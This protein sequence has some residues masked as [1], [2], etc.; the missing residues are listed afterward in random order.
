MP[1]S[2]TQLPKTAEFHI[3]SCPVTIRDHRVITRGGLTG[4]IMDIVNKTDTDRNQL[5][6]FEKYGISYEAAIECCAQELEYDTMTLAKAI[7]NYLDREG[8]PYFDEH[9][10]PEAG[11]RF[12]ECVTGRKIAEQFIEMIR[13]CDNWEDLY[14]EMQLTS[15]FHKDMKGRI[16]AEVKQQCHKV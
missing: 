7:Y 10:Y 13:S 8:I 4:Y 2:I 3:G 15:R 14:Q 12:S 16:K 1:Q 11:L 9:N 5:Y 6:E